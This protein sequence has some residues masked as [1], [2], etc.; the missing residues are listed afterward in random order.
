MNKAKVNDLF[1]IEVPE[2]FHTMSEEELR[3]AYRDDNPNRWGMWDQERH[4]MVTVMWKEY[5][6][7]LMMLADV[8]A[9]CRKN[10]QIAAKGYGN[11][12]YECG[13]FF[14]VNVDGEK[15]EGYRFSYC[16]DG[17]VQSAETILFKLGKTIF[18]VTCGGRRENQETDRE[19]FDRII[20]GISLE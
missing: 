1:S 2:G 12:G 18:T 9:I 10:E 3:K 17:V 11:N 14:S 6:R 15:A 16:V 7:L 5:S 8:K 13:G 20:D 4:V 19:L